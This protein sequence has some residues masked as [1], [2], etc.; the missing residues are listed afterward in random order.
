MTFYL[1]AFLLGL[2]MG[3]LCLIT[4]GP[5]AAPLVALGKPGW[6]GAASTLGVFLTGRLAG[7]LAIAMASSF[8]GRILIPGHNHSAAALLTLAAGLFLLIAA[9]AHSFPSLSWCRFFSSPGPSRLTVFLVGLLSG[10]NLCP[11]FIAAILSSAALASLIKSLL[12][13]LVFFVA[14]SLVF[15]VLILLGWIGERAPI[16]AAARVLLVLT[17]SWMVF[18]GSLSLFS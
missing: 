11:P 9:A 12:F 15:P 14:T 16:R 7:Y 6:K 13:F 4:C 1:E 8:L 5:L 3:P 10:L 2:S 18:K 17:G